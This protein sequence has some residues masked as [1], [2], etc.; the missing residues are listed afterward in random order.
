MNMLW[1]K[2]PNPTSALETRKDSS[3]LHS[4]RYHQYKQKMKFL[5]SV[6]HFQLDFSKDLVG[7]R[8]IF[9]SYEGHF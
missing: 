6:Y 7:N 3:F 8:F 1:Y 4:F 2:Y 5:V 9:C